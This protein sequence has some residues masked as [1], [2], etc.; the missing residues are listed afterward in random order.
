MEISLVIIYVLLFM[1]ELPFKIIDLGFIHLELYK[2]YVISTIQEGVAFDFP[3]LT[4]FFE[5]LEENYSGQPIVSIAK[6]IHDY[7]VNPTCYLIAHTNLNLL[8][9]AVV[10]VSKSAYETALFEKKF[11]KNSYEPFHTLD[12][13]ID[14]SNKLIE[15]YNKKAGL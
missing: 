4:E 3:H 10:C 8:G 11:Y 7:T 14:W 6:R 9:I 1:S 12:E 5:V 15:T 13:A 2:N